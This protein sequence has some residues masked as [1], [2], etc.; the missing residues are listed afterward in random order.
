MTNYFEQ[1]T[2]S[3]II[4]KGNQTSTEIQKSQSACQL[5]KSDHEKQIESLNSTPEADYTRKLQNYK[6]LN[7]DLDITDVRDSHINYFKLE[8]KINQ[9]KVSNLRQESQS[10]IISNLDEVAG[11]CFT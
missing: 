3:K 9:D 8:R 7:K 6:T 2:S 5:P 1:N 10:R 4:L 11:N